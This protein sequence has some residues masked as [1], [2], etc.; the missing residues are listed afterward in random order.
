MII[1]VVG[2]P[3]SGK[4]IVSD[5]AKKL[6]IP[7]LVMGDAVR[8]ETRRRGLELTPENVLRTAEDLRKRFGRKAVAL[9]V[10]DKIRRERLNRKKIIVVEGLRSPEEKDTFDSFFEKFFVIAV[11]ASPKTRYSRILGRGR[12]DDARSIEMLRKRDLKE[13]SF[14]IGDLLAMADYH[15]VNENKTKEEFINEC[16]ELM[17][18]IISKFNELQ[19]IS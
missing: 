11:H 6:G 18:K 2:M 16:R 8:E 19:E 13:L 5:S 10:I 9:L 4:S 12:Q 15:L 17:K 14:G 3:G 1:A 7:V